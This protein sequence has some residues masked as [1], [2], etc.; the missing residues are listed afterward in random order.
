MDANGREDKQN[1]SNRRLTQMYADRLPRA[2]LSILLRY[3]CVDPRSS[4]V[5]LASPDRFAFIRVH[6][7]LT[8]CVLCVSGGE[9]WFLSMIL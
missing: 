7:R 3:I 4:A 1:K 5:R 6:S 8:L 9:I 2:P